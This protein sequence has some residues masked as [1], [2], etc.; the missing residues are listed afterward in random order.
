MGM[1]ENRR[2]TTA[3]QC[4]WQPLESDSAQFIHQ[5]PE[6]LPS[7]HGA[8]DGQPPSA[9]AFQF[10]INILSPPASR[11][12]QP[13]QGMG[14]IV[15]RDLHFFFFKEEEG[16][17]GGFH[18]REKKKLGGW[19]PYDRHEDLPMECLARPKARPPRRRGSR[20]L[21]QWRRGGRR[22]SRRG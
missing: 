16:R 3:P 22:L 18:L 12:P 21:G 2:E 11:C 17:P 4:L 13:F 5:E 15:L 6:T 1:G 19:I 20:R 7:S 8:F 9:M 10:T 14:G